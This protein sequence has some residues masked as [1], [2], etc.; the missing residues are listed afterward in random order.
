MLYE[1]GQR[2]TTL[3]IPGNDS[4]GRRADEVYS[5]TLRVGVQPNG[6]S[7]RKQYLTPPA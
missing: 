3:R 2:G 1:P 4:E 6:G 5:W 7:Q